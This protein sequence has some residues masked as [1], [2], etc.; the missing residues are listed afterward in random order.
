MLDLLEFFPLRYPLL[1]PVLNTLGYFIKHKTRIPNEIIPFLLFAVASVISTGIRYV[2][3]GFSGWYFWFDIVFLYGVVNSLKLTLYAIGGYEAVRAIK[4][5]SRREEVK[6][7]MRRGFVRSILAIVVATIVI[8]LV[9]MLFGSSFLGVFGHLT[10]AWV[11]IIFYAVAFDCFGKIAKHRERITPAYIV[12]MC[13]VL[14]S[15]VLFLVAS[16]TASRF[17]GFIC[18]ALAAVLGIVAGILFVIPYIKERKRLK[19]E[20]LKPFDPEAYQKKWVR[21]RDKLQKLSAEKQKEIL[22]NFL[23]FK[24]IGNS[25]YNNV[26]LSAPLFSLADIEGKPVYVTPSKAAAY[27][28]NPEAVTRAEEYISSLVDVEHKEDK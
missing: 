21:V 25:I 13:S 18:L 22:C 24:L 26:D 20:A 6:N 4:F 12:M 2:M 10:D 7:N 15:A 16:V 9:T 3:S 11:G 19:E 8:S 17:I 28:V 1:V 5:T 23:C 27:N 14:L